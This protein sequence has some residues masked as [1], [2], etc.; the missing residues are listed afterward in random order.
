MLVH[1]LYKQDWLYSVQNK[2]TSRRPATAHEHNSTTSTD[3]EQ[4]TGVA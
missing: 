3:I 2:K 1:K 4:T